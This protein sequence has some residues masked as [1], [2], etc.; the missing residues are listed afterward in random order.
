MLSDMKRSSRRLRSMSRR[1]AGVSQSAVSR[2]FTPGSSIAEETR[3][4]GRRGGA[5]AELCAQ[6]DRQQPDHQT[7][8]YR[9]P[10]PRQHGQSVLCAGSA[11]VQPSSCRRQGRQVLLFTVEPGA[12]SDDAIMRALQYQIDGDHPDGRATFDAHDGDLPRAR[13]PDRAVQPLH[14]GQRRFGRAL[15]QR[16]R[17]PADRRGVSRRR[18]QDLRDDH[19]RPR[20][21]RRARTAFA[22]LSSGCWRKASSASES[23]KSPAARPTTA[24]S[25]RRS[26]CF[27]AGQ[28]PRPDA[29]F[30][31]NDIMAMGAM[32]ALR[33]DSA[34]RIP[35][36]LMVAGFDDIPT[37]RGPPLSVDHRRASRS[38]A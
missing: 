11:R 19:R 37:E 26:T 22:A 8:Q 16:R 38:T 34:L 17:R 27:S 9:R 12:E 3:A 6:F 31:I 13:H 2:A 18:R 33:F 1:L 23:R 10:D 32:D 20:R 36:D 28:A 25:A 35:D 7:D 30:A 4:Q 29:L 5:E 14:P 15:R 24:P 21:A